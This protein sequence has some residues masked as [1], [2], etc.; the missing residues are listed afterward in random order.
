MRGV[1]VEQCAINDD[2][3]KAAERFK[4]LPIV[5]TVPKTRFCHHMS[6]EIV[7]RTHFGIQITHHNSNF[8]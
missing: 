5:V 8:L 3:V 4:P 7:I 6:K 1:I 2:A